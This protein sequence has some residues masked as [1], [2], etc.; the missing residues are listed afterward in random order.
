[1]LQTRSSLFA[2]NFKTGTTL[3]KNQYE[4]NNE[5]REYYG[6][7]GAVAVLVY[8]GSNKIQ[9]LS[10]SYLSNG[11]NTIQEALDKDGQWKP[12]EFMFD[13]VVV[14]QVIM[15]IRSCPNIIL[16]QELLNTPEISRPN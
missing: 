9:I 11:F 2:I 16:L 15:I 5:Y 8:N 14:E 12:I 4:I 10:Q 6:D 3:L 1:M 13:F 7:T